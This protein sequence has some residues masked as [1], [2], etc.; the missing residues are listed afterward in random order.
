M[1]RSGRLLGA[2]FF[3]A[4]GVAAAPALLRLAWSW[5]H[6]VAVE[7]HSMEPTL[8]AGDWLLV[9]PDAYRA[10]APRPTEIVVARDPRTVGRLIVKR[11]RAV[12]P[13]GDVRIEGDHP[14]HAD[15][16]G[17][18]GPLPPAALKG[19]AWFRYWPIGRLGRV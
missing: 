15:D 3:T 19:R 18:L 10:R 17:A 5:Q 12:G 8:R 13:H 1:S 11:V 2:A 9:D 4:A 14:G 7:G 6:R 16:D